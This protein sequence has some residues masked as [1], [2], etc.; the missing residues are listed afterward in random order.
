MHV[1]DVYVLINSTRK[2]YSLLTGL[3]KV[4]SCRLILDAVV[5]GLEKDQG[6]HVAHAIIRFLGTQF[7]SPCHSMEC[8]LVNAPQAPV[9]RHDLLTMGGSGVDYC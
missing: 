9:H 6:V 7:L 3:L 2:Q 1:K 5:C 8:R 4:A